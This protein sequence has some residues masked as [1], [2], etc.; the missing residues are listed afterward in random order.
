MPYAAILYLYSLLWERER[1]WAHSWLTSQSKESKCMPSIQTFTPETVCLQTSL[2][3]SFTCTHTPP[4]REQ[5]SEADW[6]RGWVWEE[7]WCHWP[8]GFQLQ[9]FTCQTQRHI[10]TL[11]ATEQDKMMSQRS[12]NQHGFLFSFTAILWILTNLIWF[13]L[14]FILFSNQIYKRCLLLSSCK[15]L[16][17]CFSTV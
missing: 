12:K 11:T 8:G 15:C 3:L 7:G 13:D 1:D 4:V 17:R 16:F 9:R 5:L 6:R 14:F 2:S 10:F